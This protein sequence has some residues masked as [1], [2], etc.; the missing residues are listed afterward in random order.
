MTKRKK[1]LAVDGRISTRRQR[2]TVE[3]TVWI[4]GD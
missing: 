3:M 4:M 1:K 2:K